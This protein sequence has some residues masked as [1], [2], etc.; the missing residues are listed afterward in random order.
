M[1]NKRKSIRKAYMLSK[2]PMS[3]LSASMLNKYVFDKTGKI[4]VGTQ[5]IPFASELHDII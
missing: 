5:T 2:K 4:V 1:K 3:R